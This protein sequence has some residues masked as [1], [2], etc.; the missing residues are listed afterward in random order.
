MVMTFK[1]SECLVLRAHAAGAEFESDV[2]GG[3]RMSCRG[4]VQWCPKPAQA[5]PA[6]TYLLVF[7]FIVRYSREYGES[8]S[9]GKMSDRRKKPFPCAQENCTSRAVR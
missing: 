6:V 4:E 9:R 1:I 5:Y 2:V 8:W 7:I 3:K